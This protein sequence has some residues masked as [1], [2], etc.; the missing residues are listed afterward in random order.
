[1][2][3]AVD[4]LVQELPSITD[5]Y[6]LALVTYALHLAENP[7]RNTAFDMLQAKA[8]NSSNY[9]HNYR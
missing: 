7:N 1:M 8:D 4:F 2:N 5:P 3:K 6:T 9:D